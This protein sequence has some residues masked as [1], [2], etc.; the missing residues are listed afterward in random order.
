MNAEPGIA[1]P[2]SALRASAPRVGWRVA[3]PNLLTLARLLLAGGLIT[4]L[5]LWRYPKLD[6]QFAPPTGPMIWACLLFSLGALTDLLDGLLARRWGVISRFGRI[7]DP[8]ADKLLVVGAFAMMA[9]PAFD[10]QLSSGKALQVSGV[11][12]WMALVILSREL[13]V[14]TI[15]AVLEAR[16]IDFSATLSGKA[17]MAVQCTCIIS[18][19]L[20]LAFASPMPL[21][22][23]RK[24]I[25]AMVWT[26]VIVTA[27]SIVPYAIRAAQ[28]SASSL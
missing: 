16:G 11:M 28:A 1:T 14:T 25:D 9:G 20:I 4:L 22:P 23:A 17:K 5:S 26:S 19:F 13:L 24:F 7:M 27:L 15:R 8:F 3:V 2:P 21:M 10:V 12:P 18:V 6:E